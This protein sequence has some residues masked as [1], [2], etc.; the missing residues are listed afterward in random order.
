MNN[1]SFLEKLKS[2]SKD[3]MGMLKKIYDK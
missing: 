2:Y 3:K 1:D